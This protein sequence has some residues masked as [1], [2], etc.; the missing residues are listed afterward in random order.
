MP[1]QNEWY[2]KNGRVQRICGFN[3]KGIIGTRF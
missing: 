2:H 1:A 3:Q